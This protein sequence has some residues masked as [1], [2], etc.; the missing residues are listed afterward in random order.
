MSTLTDAQ[1]WAEAAAG[2]TD[3]FGALFDRYADRVYRYLRLRVGVPADAEDLVVTVF[4]EAWAA[5]SRLRVGAAGALPL[6]YGVARH[7]CSHYHRSRER[8]QRAWQ[9]LGPGQ[10]PPADPAE[11]VLDSMVR[12]DLG[13]Q[14][15]L[16][17]ELLSNEHRCVLELCVIGGLST[18]AVAAHLGVPE[19]TVKSRLSR[20]KAA[21]AAH[22]TPELAR[23]EEVK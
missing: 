5:R 23:S 13:A 7:T 3:A 8:A 10:P 19:G 1:L 15:R 2:Q 4:A 11:Q 21:L 20:A 6:L 18:A 16:G 17:L 14:L 22:C 12:H 9:R